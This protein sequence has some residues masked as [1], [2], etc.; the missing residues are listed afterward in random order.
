M[1]DSV[2]ISRSYK[3]S[4]SRP[5]MRRSWSSEPRIGSSRSRKAKELGVAESPLYKA[6]ALD[7]KLRLARDTQVRHL[8]DYG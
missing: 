2:L 1:C 8:P 5:A 6:L 3:I 7:F 4:R